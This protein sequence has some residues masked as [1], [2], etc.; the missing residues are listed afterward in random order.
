[1]TQQQPQFENQSPP[2]TPPATPPA[3]ATAAPT[4]NHQL[5]PAP[6]QATRHLWVAAYLDRD[7]RRAALKHVYN[8]PEHA[9]A[10]SVGVDSASVL[11]HCKRAMYLDLFQAITI[12]GL[13]LLAL[14]VSW[15]AVFVLIGLLLGWQLFKVL[16]R[17]VRN[18]A[19]W[20]KDGSSISLR[21]MTGGILLLLV[22]CVFVF[23]LFAG[24]VMALLTSLLSGDGLGSSS[25]GSTSTS[26]S[27]DASFG[28][29][30]PWALLFAGVVGTFAAIRRSW[31]LRLRTQMVGPDSIRADAR[32]AHIQNAEAGDVTCYSGYYPF[33][34]AGDLRRTWS[35]ALTLTPVDGRTDPGP[36]PGF[37]AAELTQHIGE[38]LSALGQ[39]AG[40][41][42]HIQG[43]SVTNEA[44]IAGVDANGPVNST[45]HLP[46][47]SWADSC[48]DPNT[49]IRNYIKCQVRAWDGELVTTVFAHAALQGQ[50]L[51]LEFSHLVLPPTRNEYHVFGNKSEMGPNAVVMDVLRGIG[52]LPGE[53]GQ[54]PAILFREIGNAIGASRL[55]TDLQDPQSASTDYGARVSVRYL[56]TDSDVQHYF[57]ER[58]AVKFGKVLE[59]QL[60]RLVRDFLSDK[61]DVAE[62]EAKSTSIINNSTVINGP[63][64]AVGAGASGNIGA[65][66]SSNQVTIGTGDSK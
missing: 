17:T 42:K 34:Y 2:P 63:V 20:I 56:G 38:G 8:Q 53:V 18:A 60:M 58:D 3:T 5:P 24:S 37:T 39:D 21:R 31:I 15:P 25:S 41:T 48:N 49:I 10:P 6:S 11:Y 54:A 65:V 40:H 14:A 35:L 64:A 43:L 4:Q 12:V 61:V 50:T 55:R 27:G 22:L 36:W 51:Y 9:V 16:L 57:Q 52:R 32:L 13:F 45:Q 47:Y 26:G 1:M 19:T 29:A 62:F 30:L 66:G 33:N 46:G 44:W 28:R 59:R 7:F 23:V